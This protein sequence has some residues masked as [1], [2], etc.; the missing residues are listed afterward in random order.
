M[1]L[2]SQATE[3]A[4][5]VIDRA[6]HAIVLTRVLSAPPARVFEA[7][8]R[9]QHV[10]C[11][12]D[13]AGR[14]LDTCDIDLRPG[15]TF[16]F[17]SQLASGAHRFAGIYREIAPPN[18]LVFEA[19]GAVGRVTF[20]KIGSQTRLTVRIE[21]QSAN[22][23]DQYIKMGIDAGTARTLDNLLAY[24]EKKSWHRLDEGTI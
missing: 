17:V 5:V 10:K 20:E 3:D 4:H 16:S 9:P 13:P 21:C 8:T 15:G 23:L 1:L 22:Q 11:W 14:L 2:K 7:W 19:M 12:W 18:R 24:L 6:A